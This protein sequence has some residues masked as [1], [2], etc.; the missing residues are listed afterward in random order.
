MQVSGVD[1]KCPACYNTAMEKIFKRDGSVADFDPKKIYTAIEKALKATEEDISLAKKI[2]DEV[3]AELQT[4]FGTHNPTVEDIQDLVEKH[5]VKNGKYETAKAYIIYRQSRTALRQHKEILGIKDTLKLSLNSTR[6]LEERY[7]LRDV[8]GKIKETPAGMFRR[9]AKAVAQADGNYGIDPLE[10]EEC[11]YDAMSHFEFLPNSP[12]LMNAGTNLGQLSACFVLPI[13]DS[14]T[15]IF[16]ALKYAAII[17]QSGG[18]TGFSFSKIRPKGDVVKSTM[19]IASG[20]VS[21]MRIFDRATEII[22]Q[23]G[24]RRGANIG[25]LSIDHPDILEFIRVKEK[26]GEL[27]NFNISV[28]VTDDF[29][30]KVRNNQNF[31]IINPRNGSVVKILN[32]RDVFN[33]MVMSAWKSGDPGVIYVDEINNRNPTPDIG[34]IETTNPCGEVPLLPYESCNLGSINVLNMFTNEEFDYKKLGETVQLGVHFLDN[35]ID[36]NRYPLPHIE[37]ITKGNRKIGLGIMGFADCLVRLKIPYNSQRALDF[38]EELMSFIQNEARKASRT[39]AEKRSSF[40]NIERSFFKNKGPMR[41]ATVTS[42]APTGTI[43]TIANISSGIEPLFSVGYLRNALD[44]TFLVINPMFERVARERGFYSSELM[45]QVVR[46]G[47]IQRI[48]HIP[49]DVRRLF[50][51]AHDIL[52]EFHV[53]MQ[54]VFQKYVDNAVSKTINLPEDAPLEQAGSIFLLAN[55][56]RCKGCTIYRY[57]SKRRQALEFG[58]IDLDDV[59]LPG[60]CNY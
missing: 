4:I 40:P 8:E 18:G 7:L 41:N 56:L 28:A 22:K 59:C 1:N 25:V 24:K 48:A 45:A 46:E 6:I 58:D 15:E 27:D 16:D 60:V 37:K 2:G 3:I 35:V 53:K 39:L 11:F 34:K 20:P 43:S 9:V 44:T 21:F 29:I 49:G 38:A 55:K 54:A 33:L 51:T 47:S 42:I 31:E 36:V 52:P 23:G 12:A 10:S 13:G 32:A 50:P 26:E 57:G 30:S 14:L 17:H 19:G 5:L